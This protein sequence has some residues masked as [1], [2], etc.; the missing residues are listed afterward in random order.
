[1]LRA[2]SVLK[3]EN[4]ARSQ[5]S[6][7]S[8][9]QG[10]VVIRLLQKALAMDHALKLCVAGELKP[11]DMAVL[12]FIATNM[13]NQTGETVRIYGTFAARCG[14]S[15]S[16]IG[17]SLKR[18]KDAGVI[19]VTPRYARHSG[20]VCS[21]FRFSKEAVKAKALP[22]A[23]SGKA[24]GPSAEA[25]SGK[26]SINVQNMGHPPSQERDASY[27]TSR[28]HSFPNGRPGQ[29]ACK[30]EA[31]WTAIEDWLVEAGRYRQWGYGSR[32]CAVDDLERWRR[33]NGDGRI[34]SAINKAKEKCLYG[35]VRIDFLNNT[36]SGRSK[37]A[38]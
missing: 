1:M 36:W 19:E 18:L 27:S 15:R 28:L 31:D 9:D 24:R 14:M 10:P 26:G 20:R 33:E 30:P 21:A 3:S 32:S 29:S 8:G 5:T 4:T 34:L 16:S 12:W 35:A 7:S 6:K 25:A 37:G 11:D 2:S 23:G 22:E 38:A 13:D 17:R